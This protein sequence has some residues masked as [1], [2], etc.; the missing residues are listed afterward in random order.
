MSKR[1]WIALIVVPLIVAAYFWYRG[2]PFGS[3]RT[4]A[5]VNFLQH[6]DAHPDWRVTARTRCGAAPFL[7]PSSGMIGYIWDD[8]FRPGH[9]HQGIDLFGGTAPGETPVYAVYDGYLTRLPNWKSA[10]IM[11]IPSDPL[12]PS[13]QIWVYYA[14]MADPDGNSFI[15]A[16]FPPGTYEQFVPAGTLLG[17]QGNYSGNPL[18]PTGVHLHLSIVRDDGAGHFLNET[19][20]GN[21]LDPSPYFGLA[22]NARNNP[23]QIPTCSQERP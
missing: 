13:R 2:W 4:P 5:V 8:S 7:I 17:Y 10:V 18:K 22:L 20:I 3:Q 11:R 6:P 23:D 15:S 12:N 19:D 14:H 16:D 1:I 9:R 21:T